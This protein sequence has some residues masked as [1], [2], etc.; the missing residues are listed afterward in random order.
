MRLAS[1]LV[2]TSIGLL[3]GACATTPTPVAPTLFV[4]PLARD[5]GA[6]APQNPGGYSGQSVVLRPGAD[7]GRGI[8]RNS[9]ILNA[10]FGARQLEDSRWSPLD[11]QFAAGVDYTF[12]GRD[13]WIGLN[14][15]LSGGGQRETVG[16]QDVDSWQA[17][18]SIGPRVYLAIPETPIYL[19]GGVSVA[20]AYGEIE[21]AQ[22]RRTSDTFFAGIAS[23]GLMF[24]LNR[25]QAIG[26]EYRALQGG[27]FSGSVPGAPNDAN[28]HQLSLTFS[29]AF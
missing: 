26:V 15:G 9:G 21:V 11:D 7:F 8:P 23:A 13:S 24:K 28:S 16:G 20:L 17:E 5:G 6:A 3:S 19:Y 22:S 4:A 29:A 10:T 2:F 18:A 25:S 27:G 12:K 1:I 14:V